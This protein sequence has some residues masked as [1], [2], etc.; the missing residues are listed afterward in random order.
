MRERFLM[1][2]RNITKG[3]VPGISTIISSHQVIEVEYIA[4]R[5]LYLENG[6]VS[7]YGNSKLHSLDST[8]SFFEFSASEAIHVE[9]LSKNFRIKVLQLGLSY[10][11]I[12]P[13]KIDIYELIK[14]FKQKSIKI[15]Y[16]RDISSSIKKVILSKD[17]DSKIDLL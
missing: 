16:I 8:L 9:S 11:V 13:S 14:I 17:I 4:D 1:D 2:L 3:L 10:I 7:Y 15:I 5:T 6:K 12:T